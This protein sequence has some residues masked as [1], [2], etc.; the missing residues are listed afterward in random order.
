VGDHAVIAA[1]ALPAAGERI[2][3][4]QSSHLW[5]GCGKGERRTDAGSNLSRPIL[6]SEASRLDPNLQASKG[7]R[8]VLRLPHRISHGQL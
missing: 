4:Q 8:E 1:E 3:G 6:L 5:L 2:G 7:R